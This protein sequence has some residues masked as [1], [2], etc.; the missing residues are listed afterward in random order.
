MK[1]TIYF[2]NN[3]ETPF[4]V[5]VDGVIAC[6]NCG[7]SYNIETYDYNTINGNNIKVEDIVVRMNHEV[8]IWFYEMCVKLM[9]DLL[10]IEVEIKNKR[11]YFIYNLNGIIHNIKY[12]TTIIG[13]WKTYTL[14]TGEDI[15]IYRGYPGCLITETD[16]RDIMENLMSVKHSSERILKLVEMY[17]PL[18]Q[19]DEENPSW[20][21]LEEEVDGMLKDIKT[22][23]G[24]FKYGTVVK[25]RN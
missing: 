8:K 12:M 11:Y 15:Y 21:N 23:Y 5:T 6:P 20:D 4:D 18:F 13:S 7:L 14:T 2:C 22:L 1:Q 19:C 25:E 24:F 16:W 9:R 3:C 17:S 10:Y